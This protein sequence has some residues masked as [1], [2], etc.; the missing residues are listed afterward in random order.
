MSTRTQTQRPL[1]LPAYF[2]VYVYII[3]VPSSH[4][5]HHRLKLDARGRLCA[6]VQSMH[7]HERKY[8]RKSVNEKRRRWCIEVETQRA[9]K[10]RSKT[11]YRKQWRDFFA[12]FFSLPAFFFFLL[13]TSSHH[14]LLL[15]ACYFRN[16]PYTF[17]PSCYV[18]LLFSGRIFLQPHSFILELFGVCRWGAYLFEFLFSISSPIKYVMRK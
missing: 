3:F 9:G 17:M 10:R 15:I 13:S 16:A 1:A 6:C 18:F 5:T 4:S 8:E 12:F 14:H 2:C 7:S 11:V